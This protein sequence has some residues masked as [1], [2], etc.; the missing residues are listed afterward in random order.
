[1][2][3]FA[4]QDSISFKFPVTLISSYCCALRHSYYHRQIGKIVQG[5]KV[6]T[7]AMADILS[8]LLEI[9][10]NWRTC[11]KVYGTILMLNCDM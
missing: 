4:Y 8:N 5:I 11:H 6:A 7:F 3:S 2:N 10:S 9:N 1:M